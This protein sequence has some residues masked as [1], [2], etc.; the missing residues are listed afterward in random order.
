VKNKSNIFGL[1]LTGVLLLFSGMACM[2]VMGWISPPTAT[3][4]PTQTPAS[5]PATSEAIPTE[6]SVPD[7][8]ASHIPLGAVGEYAHYPPS[9][10]VHYAQT[11]E[12]GFY[13]EEAPPEY[14]VHNLEHG[15]V[16]VLYN[17]AED[18]EDMKVALKEFFAIA[19]PEDVFNAVKLVISP[20]DKIESPVVALAWGWQLDLQTVDV[21]ALSDFYLRYVNQGPELV[22]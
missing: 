22:P 12:W 3:P 17:C 16:V 18:C 20:D 15:G 14:Y 5:P 8:G 13:E 2:T 1:L 9:S 7:E 21:D 11:V 6:F 4:L 19:P 10:G